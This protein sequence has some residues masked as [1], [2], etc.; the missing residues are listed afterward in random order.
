[1]APQQALFSLLEAL[2]DSDRGAAVTHAR[3]L[4]DWLEKEGFFPTVERD[5]EGFFVSSRAGGEP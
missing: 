2:A 5:R 3:D 1:M 4:A